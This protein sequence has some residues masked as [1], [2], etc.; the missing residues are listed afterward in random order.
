[1]K[2]NEYAFLHLS[3]PEPLRFL[4]IIIITLYLQIK[5]NAMGDDEE[6][7]G[8]PTRP[9]FNAGDPVPENWYNILFLSLCLLLSLLIFLLHYI[10]PTSY[11]ASSTFPLLFSLIRV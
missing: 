1:M 2:V 7:K 10:S 11:P 5:V 6:H 4:L 3:P 8:H 9:L